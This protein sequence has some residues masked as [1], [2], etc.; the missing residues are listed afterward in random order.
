[1]VLTLAEEKKSEP[2]TFFASPPPKE[3]GEIVEKPKEKTASIVDKII[4]NLEQTYREEKAKEI[5]ILYNGFADVITNHKAHISN[6]LTAI[7]LIKHD[8]IMQQI[9]KIRSEQG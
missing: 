3:E 6:I 8:V 5:Q 4:E 2:L 9:Q 1:V 7:E